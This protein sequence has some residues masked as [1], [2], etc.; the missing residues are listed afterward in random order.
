M[1]SQ[2]VVWGKNNLEN[3]TRTWKQTAAIWDRKHKQSR[4]HGDPF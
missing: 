3:H 4:Q 1:I 2:Q